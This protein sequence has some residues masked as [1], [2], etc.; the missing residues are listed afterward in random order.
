MGTWIH[1]DL[2]IVLRKIFF[3]I[4]ETDRD[5]PLRDQVP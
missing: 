1:F 2:K 5:V 3:L 4:D